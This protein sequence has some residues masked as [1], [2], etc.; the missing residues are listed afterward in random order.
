MVMHGPPGA[1]MTEFLYALLLPLLLLP[2]AILVAAILVKVLSMRAMMQE[3]KTLAP[4]SERDKA[5]IEQIEAGIRDWLMLLELPQLEDK[6]KL[7]EAARQLRIVLVE[8]LM[9]GPRVR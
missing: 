6:M 4:Q 7:Q 5:R 8:K 1:E 9:R 2:V 3:V